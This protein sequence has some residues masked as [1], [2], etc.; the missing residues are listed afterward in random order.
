MNTHDLAIEHLRLQLGSGVDAALDK[1]N[2]QALRRELGTIGAGYHS[3][4]N[5]SDDPPPASLQMGIR[6][7]MA[8]QRLFVVM[9]E[10]GLLVEVRGEPARAV[11][12]H[13]KDVLPS[14]DA[15][16]ID[17][18]GL[19]ESMIEVTVRRGEEQE[20]SDQDIEV[21]VKVDPDRL[22]GALI[23]DIHDSVKWDERPKVDSQQRARRV[24]IA[25]TIARML[26]GGLLIGG[27]AALGVLSPLDFSLP[28]TTSTV[29]VL[30]GIVGSI[31]VGLSTVG[32]GLEK[33]SEEIG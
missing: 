32:S 21:L 29:P 14:L 17:D 23:V 10:S 12:P 28:T 11:R 18:D 33:L 24:R 9:G 6:G 26:A 16:L 25:G 7:F 13:V 3:I 20:V 4:R 30:V 8:L 22:A 5:I 15:Q 31:G 19:L 2:Y 1:L 27:N